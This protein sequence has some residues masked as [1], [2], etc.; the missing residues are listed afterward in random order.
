[1]VVNAVDLVS[2]LARVLNV[3]N[4]DIFYHNAGINLQCK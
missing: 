2:T 3:A 1:M 4:N